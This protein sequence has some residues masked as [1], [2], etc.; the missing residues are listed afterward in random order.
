MDGA[1]DVFRSN[2][3]GDFTKAT[4]RVTSNCTIW[5]FCVAFLAA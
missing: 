5:P 2:N 4:S 3:N 1:C